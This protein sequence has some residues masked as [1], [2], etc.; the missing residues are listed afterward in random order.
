MKG[1]AEQTDSA[2]PGTGSGHFWLI[3]NE[4]TY[5]INYANLSAPATAAYLHGPA[6]V[7]PSTGMRIPLQATAGM[8]GVAGAFSGASTLAAEQLG[9]LVDGLTYVSIQ[10]SNDPDG[11][12]RGQ[13]TP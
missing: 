5:E 13:V 2:S 3:G 4:L 9:H 7:D 1:A 10:T 6:A 12:L 11:E 8:L